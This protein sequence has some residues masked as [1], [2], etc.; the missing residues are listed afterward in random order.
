MKYQIKKL[1]ANNFDVIEI[2]KAKARSYFIPYSSKEK[3]EKENVLTQRYNSDLV[4]VLSGDDWKFK[5]YEKLSR[6]PA[7]IDTGSTLFDVV[8]VPSTWQRTGYEKPVYLNIRYPFKA[9]YPL[10]PSEMSAGVYVKSFEIKDTTKHSFITFL[11]VCSC[12]TLYVNGK[13]VGYSEC[14]HNMAEFCLDGFVKSGE[15]ELLAIVTK[16]CNGTYLESQDMFRENGIFRDVYITQYSESAYI[17]DYH[18]KASGENGNY[19]LSV[20]IDVLGHG[21]S[22]MSVCAVIEKD[23]KQ[24]VSQTANASSKTKLFFANLSVEEWNAEIPQ[25]YD[26]YITLKTKDEAV[27]VVKSK[28]GFK[29]VKID[30]EIFLFNGKKIKFKGVNHHDTHEDNGY[31]MSAEDLLKDVLLMKEYNVNCVRTSHYPPDPI[32]LDL[33]DQYG[34]YVI[35]EADIETHGTQCT[36]QMKPTFKQNVLSNSKAWRPRYIDRVARMYERDKNHASITMWSLGNESGGWKNHDKCYEMLKSLSDLPVHYE[37]AI[38]TVRGSYDVISEMYQHPMIVEK[39]AQHKLSARYKGK[40]YFL[41]EY[42][43]AMGV[44]PGSLEDYWKII[45]SHDQLTGG[46]IWE[47]ADHSVHDKN[48]KNE[49]TYGG[50]HGEEYHDGNFC[51]DGLFY[52][53]RNPH[54]GALAMQAV[55]RPIRSEFVSDNLY[56]FTNTNRFLN[57][58]NYDITYELLEDAVV[59]D[60]GTLALELAPESNKSVVI[61]H[62]MTGKDKNYHINFIYRRKDGSFVAKEQIALNEV[63]RRPEISIKRAVA[64]VKKNDSIIVGFENG[65]AVF[66]KNTGALESYTVGS[67]EILSSDKGFSFNLFR[68]PL[69]NDRNKIKSWQKQ[70]LDK[71]RYRSGKITKCENKE[72]EHCVQIKTEGVIEAKDKKLFDTKLK[73]RIYPDGTITVTAKISRSGFNLKP[74]QLSRFGLTLSLDASFENVEYF[75][76]GEAENLPD[77]CQQSTMGIYHGDVYSMCENYIKPQENAMHG[78]THYVKFTDSQ[79]EGIEIRS[80]KKDFSFSAR[81]YS[82]EVLK[83]AKHIEDLQYNNK[84]TLNIDGFVRGTGSNSC[85]PDVLSQYDLQIK[86]SLKFSFYIRAIKNS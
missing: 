21:L 18:A 58:D 65:R 75:G 27:Q 52:P 62:K 7:N 80:R 33:C 63:V 85:G 73:Y 34:L 39:I 38:R 31:V 42:C 35:D 8:T 59:I 67:K 24:I 70:G 78:K 30:G 37:G 20:E 60:S 45:Y 77:F 10:V 50:D 47:W 44:G 40:P 84:I 41:C 49:Y 17:Y 82:N 25:L 28:I 5:Y 79:G 26:L 53:N 3:L 14:S 66:N 46:C 16:W 51:V 19:D 48:A 11:G 2:G 1:E 22:N 6:M 61:A 64:F 55:Y 12:L 69:D 74:I 57:A 29:N 23:G 72:Q 36:L 86:D 83:K 76:L 9:N 71:L 54:T 56:K 13:L 81:P 15:N 43:H 68:A 32:F 4:T